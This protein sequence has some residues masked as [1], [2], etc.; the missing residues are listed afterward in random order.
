MCQLPHA[1]GAFRRVVHRLQ[2]GWSAQP[3]Y[4][5]LATQVQI[6]RM[7]ILVQHMLAILHALVDGAAASAHS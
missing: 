7:K 6:A 1:H 5:R 3:P 2:Y 4:Q